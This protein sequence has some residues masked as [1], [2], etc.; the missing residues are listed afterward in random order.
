MTTEISMYFLLIELITGL[1]ALLI[2][3]L[4]HCSLFYNII[5]KKSLKA[6]DMSPVMFVYIIDEIII[7][8]SI[9]MYWTFLEIVYYYIYFWMVFILYQHLQLLKPHG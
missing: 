7:S 3:L 2:A 6:I 9:L 1:V 8:I 5:W 4:I